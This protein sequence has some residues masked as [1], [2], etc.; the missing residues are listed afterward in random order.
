MMLKNFK[1][2]KN[3]FFFILEWNKFLNRKFLLILSKMGHHITHHAGLF[4]FLWC[5]ILLAEVHTIVSKFLLAPCLCIH[6]S[7]LG[8]QST[9]TKIFCQLCLGVGGLRGNRCWYI[10]LQ[11]LAI[12]CHF[13]HKKTHTKITPPRV[14][15]PPPQN[16]FFCKL[17]QKEREILPLL[18]ASGCLTVYQ[19]DVHHSVLVVYKVLQS[20]SPEYL[21]ST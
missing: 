10:F 12:L 3:Q 14:P 8:S 16:L 4:W 15:S 13:F 19:L 2:W 17:K 20:K 9:L 7:L 1:I 5:A 18:L 21:T 6:N 11:F